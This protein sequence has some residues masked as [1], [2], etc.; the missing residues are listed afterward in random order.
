MC[1]GTKVPGGN[2]ACHEN[3]CSVHVLRHI[4]LAE[5]VP[6]DALHAF[7]GAGDAGDFGFS[8]AGPSLGHALRR[9]GWYS[10]TV[11]QT[12]RKRSF[13]VES[14]FEYCSD[15]PGPHDAAF[16]ITT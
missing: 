3:E 8:W 2:V 1:G 12:W 15:V 16:S 5:D 10:K 7:I 14:L 11:D 6:G 13:T 4:G 9:V